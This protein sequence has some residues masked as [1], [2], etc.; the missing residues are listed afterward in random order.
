MAMMITKADPRPSPPTRGDGQCGLSREGESHEPC[1]VATA[2]A[3][4]GVRVP[5]PAGLM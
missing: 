4:V 3:V 2:A 1:A 5:P